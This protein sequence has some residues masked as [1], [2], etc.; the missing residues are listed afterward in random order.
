VI[1][2][3]SWEQWVLGY[4]LALPRLVAAFAVLPFFSQQVLTGSLRGGV[5][6]SL[7][8]IMVPFVAVELTP[9]HLSGIQIGLIVGKE[10]LVG[11]LVGYPIAVLFWSVEAVGFYIDNQRGAAM[12]SSADPLTGADTT[13]LGIL[14]TQAFT[15]Y[16]VM[17]GAF[18]LLL[19]VLYQTY[20]I[21][22]VSSFVPHFGAGGPDFYLVLFDQGMQL[23]M[24][25]SAPV[26]IAMF[27]TE[28]GLALVSRF[29]PQLNVF[30][31]AM[32]IKSAVAVGL[33]ILYTPI[34]FRHVMGYGGGLEGI[35]RSVQAV[36]Q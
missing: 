31:L 22:P 23:V 10:V 28:F 34:M 8:L 12:A 25:L 9:L 2:S 33:L 7:G 15:V 24:V 3:L 32:P 36:L 29:A 4:S 20:A 16:F 17:S 19:G 11:L 30:F 6:A 5:A 1:R 21:W 27:L 18:L 14:F 13:P 26:I 35:W